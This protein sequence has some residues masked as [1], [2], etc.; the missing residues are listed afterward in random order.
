M[1]LRV[2]EDGE[3]EGCM[4]IMRIGV[5]QS[6]NITPHESGQ[7]SIRCLVTR[8]FEKPTEQIRQ[9]T[10]KAGAISHG[11]MNW[12]AI[13]WEKVHYEVRRLQARIVKVTQDLL[14]NR[15][16]LCK[17]FERLEPCAGKLCAVSR[18]ER[19]AT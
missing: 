9:M 6:G 16:L 3:S 12:H 17:A 18:T 11:A 1:G 4:V 8:E 13:E 2:W 10:A 14:G 7:T 15:V 19:I 5:E